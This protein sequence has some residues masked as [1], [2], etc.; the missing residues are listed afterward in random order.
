MVQL[1]LDTRLQ[2]RVDAS[3]VVQDAYVDGVERLDGY[4][5]DPEHPPVLKLPKWKVECRERLG[6][7]FRHDHLVVAH[8]FKLTSHRFTVSSSLA[9]ARVLPSGLHDT[10][11]TLDV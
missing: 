4:L 10:E 1:R 2:S 8:F 3:D 9:V 5:Q 11:R 6:G 7:L